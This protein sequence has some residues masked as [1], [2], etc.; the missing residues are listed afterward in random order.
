MTLCH[1]LARLKVE[2]RRSILQRL[3]D[4]GVNISWPD[5]QML[6]SRAT[7]D[8]IVLRESEEYQE[9]RNNLEEIEAS[10]SEMPEENVERENDSTSI[11]RILRENLERRTQEIINEDGTHEDVAEQMREETSRLESYGQSIQFRPPE[12]SIAVDGS[13]T[14]SSSGEYR[15]SYSPSEELNIP[16]R[17]GHRIEDEHEINLPS[18]VSSGSENV[19]EHST[20]INYVWIPELQVKAMRFVHMSAC[21]C[22]ATFRAIERIL[23]DADYSDE[24]DSWLVE[25]SLVVYFEPHGTYVFIETLDGSIS[26]V[27][28][29][30]HNE[31]T[32]YSFQEPSRDSEWVRN[33]ITLR[34]HNAE[35]LFYIDASEFNSMYEIGEESDNDECE[36][37]QWLYEVI[38]GDSAMNPEYMFERRY[39][40]IPDAVRPVGMQMF[41]RSGI[42]FDSLSEFQKIFF[43]KMFWK[44]GNQERIYELF[45]GGMENWNV[46][47]WPRSNSG[48]FYGIKQ[49]MDQ[50]VFE[51]DVLNNASMSLSDLNEAG[52]EAV[53]R[54]MMDSPHVVILTSNEVVHLVRLFGEH[55]QHLDRWFTD[56]RDYEKYRRIIDLDELTLED[57][58]PSPYQER[59]DRETEGSIIWCELVAKRDND[60]LVLS[61]VAYIKTLADNT[62]TDISKWNIQSIF[63]DT[64]LIR[65]DAND[66]G[67][68]NQAFF[69]ERLPS[70]YIGFVPIEDGNPREVTDAD[71]ELMLSQVRDDSFSYEQMLRDDLLAED[72]KL[73]ADI[74]RIENRAKKI[75]KMK[76][77]LDTMEGNKTFNRES[78]GK[79]M[80]R[81]AKSG[82]YKFLGFNDDKVVFENVRPFVLKHKQYEQIHSIKVGKFK[83]HVDIKSFKAKMKC[84][85]DYETPFW[86]YKHPY[87]PRNEFL[88][89]GAEETKRVKYYTENRLYDLMLLIRDLMSSYSDE[90]P[91]CRIEH[92]IDLNNKWIEAQE[93]LS[94]DDESVQIDRINTF[95]L[96]MSGFDGIGNVAIDS[97]KK[98]LIM[99][100]QAKEYLRN[101]GRERARALDE[102]VE[103]ALENPMD[104]APF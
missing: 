69:A 72:K 21:G 77:R 23:C 90:N 59:I 88:C 79:E 99:A 16:L 45:D 8:Y 19:I 35:Q 81:I 33:R 17:D 30:A 51:Y 7:D 36:A 67:K 63:Y 39:G 29:L 78:L 94:L 86:Q 104:E 13:N 32:S 18:W 85:D 53:H 55:Y 52:T 15:I 68:I 10:M 43:G 37:G 1:L 47:V 57:V 27:Y 4:V 46:V 103:E 92:F 50:N 41:D 91:H 34:N 31:I 101:Y 89:F 98:E 100:N 14:S 65:S 48:L 93:I 71:I 22:L 76:V 42:G 54:E 20:G 64:E 61:N 44:I 66:R 28:N 70:E 82:L 73:K 83:I 5:Y 62:M 38:N 40:L 60:G 58:F 74:T 24:V 75:K 97:V 12:W 56:Y 11:A 9:I 26:L 95:N 102:A 49:A 3:R 25:K 6:H 87:L 2:N 80:E 84:S 96:S